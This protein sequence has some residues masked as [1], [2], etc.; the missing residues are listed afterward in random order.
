MI[1]FNQPSISHPE[2]GTTTSTCWCPLAI[3]T[4]DTSMAFRDAALDL[5]VKLIGIPMLVGLCQIFIFSN[6]ITNPS[7]WDKKIFESVYLGIRNLFEDGAY[8]K[9][10]HQ[11]CMFVKKIMKQSI[12]A[13][14]K[15]SKV[16]D[17]KSDG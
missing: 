3:V 8:L 9:K 12:L 14:L 15:W 17:F 6:G 1:I 5:G 13:Y 11:T 10:I 16:G 2:L 7:N 4:Q